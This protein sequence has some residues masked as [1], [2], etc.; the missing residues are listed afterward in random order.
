MQKIFTQRGRRTRKNINDNN[1]NK[2]NN[3]TNQ[4]LMKLTTNNNNKNSFSV[5]ETLHSNLLRPL[6]TDRTGTG[7]SVNNSKNKKQSK[8]KSSTQ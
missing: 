7:Y 8:T 5:S 6:P 1:S 2:S 4:K 3:K